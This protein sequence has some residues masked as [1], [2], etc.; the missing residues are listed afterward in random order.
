MMLSLWHLKGWKIK[1]IFI[2]PLERYNHSF[3]S[4]GT[5]QIGDLTT[6]TLSECKEVCGVVKLNVTLKT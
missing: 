3:L 4:V 6:T 5:L 1:H 2:K